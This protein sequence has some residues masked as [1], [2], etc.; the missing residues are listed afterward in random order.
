MQLSSSPVWW[1]PRPTTRP[2]LQPSWWAKRVELT[3]PNLSAS[4][5]NLSHCSSSIHV[6]STPTYIADHQVGVV[7]CLQGESQQASAIK[8]TTSAAEAA[9]K[10]RNSINQEQQQRQ[11]G[12]LWRDREEDT[13]LAALSHLS[14]CLSNRLWLVRPITAFSAASL[15]WRTVQVWRNIQQLICLVMGF[16][17]YESVFTVLSFAL[18]SSRWCWDQCPH[19][20]SVNRGRPGAHQSG[21]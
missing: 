8:T 1:A 20:P 17:S 9:E 16:S 21:P 6:S 15:S 5:R 12:Q 19:L 3:I 14:L 13:C 7:N 10:N 18:L 2:N 4:L 11:V